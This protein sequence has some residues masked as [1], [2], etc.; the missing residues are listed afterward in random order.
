MK[1]ENRDIKSIKLSKYNP[2][3]ISKNAHASLVA[4]IKRFGFVDPVI[5][6]DRTGVLVGGHQRINAAKDLGLVQIPVVSVDLDEAEEKALNVALNKISGE[7]D[8]DLLRG[9]LEDVQSAGL[10]LSLTGFS[11]EEWSAMSITDSFP[12]IELQN[13]SA[14]EIHV[15]DFN[16]DKKC[17]RCGFEFNEEV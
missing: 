6:N 1:V 5:V 14:K 2:R 10:E 8:L 17:P 11:D 3:K 15:D 16:F 9:V 13:S 7:W 12:K 4:S